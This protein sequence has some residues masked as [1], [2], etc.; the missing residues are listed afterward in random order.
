MCVNFKAKNQP[1][2]RNLQKY[3]KYCRNDTEMEKD[4]CNS[5]LH[6]EILYSCLCDILKNKLDIFSNLQFLQNYNRAKRKF[7]HTVKSDDAPLE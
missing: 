7:I 5:H 1:K 2:I 4:K 6:A 3:Q